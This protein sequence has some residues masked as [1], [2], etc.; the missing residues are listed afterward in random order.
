MMRGDEI[1]LITSS[2][3]SITLRNIRVL[4]GE[5]DEISLDT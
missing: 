5:R 3:Y 4:G 1:S 2:D